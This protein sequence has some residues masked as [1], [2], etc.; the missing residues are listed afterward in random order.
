IAVTLPTKDLATPYV[1]QWH[2]TLEHQFLGDYVA[3]AAYV[4]TKGT[5]LTRL[6][7]PNL[8]P[9]T[10]PFIPIVFNIQ[11]QPPAVLADL[12]QSVIRS[13]PDPFLGAV[14]IFENSAASSYHALQL[15]ARKR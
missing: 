11:D 3:S 7:T 2:L 6:T 8:G 9:N 15:E 10:T 4:G 13:R 5:K 14:Q 12:V 1:Q